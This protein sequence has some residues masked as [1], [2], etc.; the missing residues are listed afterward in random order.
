MIKQDRLLRSGKQTEWQMSK[1]AK[2]ALA[3]NSGDEQNVNG[4]LVN[5]YLVLKSAGKLQI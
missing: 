1:S 3:E 5:Q 4:L 2:A